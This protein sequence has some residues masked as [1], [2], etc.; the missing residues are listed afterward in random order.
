VG[1]YKKL[2]KN[3]GLIGIG[4]IASKLLVFLLVPLY[5]AVLTTEEYGVADTLS[6]INRLAMPVLLLMIYDGVMRFALDEFT[7]KKDVFSFGLNM[8]AV[9][10]VALLLLSPGLRFIDAIRDNYWEF[11]ALFLTHAFYQVLS[12]FCRGIERVGVYALGG[13]VA[14]VVAVVLNI[15]F[16]LVFKMGLLGYFL[17]YILAYAIADVYLLFAA[18]LWRYY[19]RPQSID[20]TLAKEMTRYSAPLVMNAAS[21][22][23]CNFAS[24]YMLILLVGYSATG[25]FAVSNKIPTI[26]WTF[27]VIFTSAWRISA[28]ED[29]GSSETKKYYTNIFDLY[30][31]FCFC[32]GAGLILLSKP[33]GFILY[34]NDFFV[35]WK[36]SPF[37]IMA[38]VSYKL[39]EF[40]MSVYTS[41][42]RTRN[43]IVASILGAVV[44]TVASLVLI[45]YHGIQ[46]ASIATL[47]GHLAVLTFC[48]ID[49]RSIMK[50]GLGLRG[51]IACFLL[52]LLETVVVVLD[53]RFSFAIALIPVG[54]I[55]LIKRKSLKSVISVLLTNA[56]ALRARR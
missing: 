3:I 42:K 22:W 16:L 33:I 38:A 19:K 51:N 26:L 31:T 27:G 41:S 54:A 11:M 23:V 45:H 37:L 15:L 20:L 5:T 47:L 6:I 14:T 1:R 29:F 28:V 48:L 24:R 39:A 43:I 53:S 10:F 8:V 55:F 52:L 46:G 25:L 30:S 7:D 35:A 12:Y 2:G 13:L 9:G 17:S 21:W 4:S 49:T 34:A 36:F 44:C 40:M 50:F 32:V 18:S 56:I